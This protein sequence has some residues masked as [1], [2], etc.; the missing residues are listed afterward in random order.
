MK[1]FVD[2]ADTAGI[3]S[4]AAGGPLDGVDANPS[5]VAKSGKK[6][7]DIIREI[8]AIVPRLFVLSVA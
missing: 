6:F 8:C 7:T 1:L 3:K 4:L 5:L 2:S